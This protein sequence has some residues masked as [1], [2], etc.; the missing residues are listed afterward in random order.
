MQ[1][2][3]TWSRARRYVLTSEVTKL[4]DVFADMAGI[5]QRALENATQTHTTSQ[6][7]H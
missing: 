2:G 6:I 3:P 7:I 4:R 5:H 1:R